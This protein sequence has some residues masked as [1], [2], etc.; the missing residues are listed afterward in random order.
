MSAA[1]TRDRR[2]VVRL[3]AA[4]VVI[5]SFAV[6]AWFAIAASRS[7]VAVSI[8]KRA[9]EAALPP[10]QQLPAVP[11]LASFNQP[12]PSSSSSGTLG[13]VVPA[14]VAVT[15]AETPGLAPPPELPDEGNI[16]P[17]CSLGLPPADTSGGLA[18]LI[19]IV[20]I[21]GSF[22]PEVFAFLPVME[23]MLAAGSPLLPVFE[24]L[25]VAGAPVLDVGVPVVNQL[26]NAL[27]DGVSAFYEP[28][29]PSVLSGEAEFAAAIAPYVEQILTAPGSECAIAAEG[30]LADLLSALLPPA[31]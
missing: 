11:S 1:S 9:A 31:R 27:F 6:L 5:I 12:L 22:S 14:A 30:V 10:V 25:I 29:R 4:G 2:Q 8:A 26:V 13:G 23:P 21:F 17:P 16:V 7:D 24:Q 18:N 28:I 15:P 19:G 3:V 20:P